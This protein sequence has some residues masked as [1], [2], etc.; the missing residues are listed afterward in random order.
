[1]PLSCAPQPVSCPLCDFPSGSCREHRSGSVWER[2]HPACAACLM[3]QIYTH[4]LEGV[5]T[6]GRCHSTH[7]LVCSLFLKTSSIMCARAGTQERSIRENADSPH[8]RPT[9]RAAPHARQHRSRQPL[10]WRGSGTD[11][12]RLALNVCR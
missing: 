6:S 8:A 9:L 12:L 11:S 1:M 2:L 10:K 7:K 4:N 5:G 3:G